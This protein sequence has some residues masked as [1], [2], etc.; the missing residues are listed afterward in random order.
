MAP[1]FSTLAKPNQQPQ[2]QLKKLVLKGTTFAK[3]MKNV[4]TTF[5]VS[6]LVVPDFQFVL[7]KKKQPQQQQQHKHL[8]ELKTKSVD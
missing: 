4:V 7:K 8:A 1:V 6:P 2:Q 5:S 3:W